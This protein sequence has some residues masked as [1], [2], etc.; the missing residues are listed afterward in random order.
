MRKQRVRDDARALAERG[1]AAADGGGH[2]AVVEESGDPGA[3]NGQVD[4]FEGRGGVAEPGL[5]VAK[6][7]FVVADGVRRDVFAAQT[8]DELRDFRRQ[9]RH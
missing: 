4:V 9:F 5:E 1:D 6:I 2:L 8:V 7:A 3:E